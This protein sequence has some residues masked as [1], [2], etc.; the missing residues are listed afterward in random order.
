MNGF[1][2][3]FISLLALAWCALL[4]GALL[5]IWD[6]NREI[7]WSSTNFRALFDVVTLTRSEQILGTIIAGALMLPAIMLLA[8]ELKPSPRRDVRDPRRDD[9]EQ[10]VEALQRQLEAER[11]QPDVTTTAEP[12]RRHEGERGRFGRMMPWRRS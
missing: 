3:A 11:R 7:N 1:N 6:L 5:M 10:R 9:L 4:G 12:V 8:F 2:R